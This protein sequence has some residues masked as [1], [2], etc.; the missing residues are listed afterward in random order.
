MSLCLNSSTRVLDPCK[1]LVSYTDN[2]VEGL[3]EFTYAQFNFDG[4]VYVD[5]NNQPI[6]NTSNYVNQECCTKIGGTPMLHYD[7]ENN[8][9]INS[10]YFCCDNSG[11]C[12]CTIACDWMVQMD[13]VNLIEDQGIR[14]RPHYLGFVQPNGYS[15]M[16]TPDGCHCVG[17]PYTILVPDVT[18]PYTGQVGVACQLTTLGLEDLSLGASE[19]YIYN[20]Y[21]ERSSGNSS[22]FPNNN[23]GLPN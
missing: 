20:Y 6:Y 21:L 2:I 10:G 23:S 11:K 9:T 16:V 18:D 15:S 19:S 12:G 14:P 8:V 4:S 13:Y 17:S 3:Y 22:C 1:N 5:V 7:I